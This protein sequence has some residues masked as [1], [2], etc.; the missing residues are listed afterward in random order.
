MQA[1]VRAATAL[2]RPPLPGDIRDAFAAPYASADR[3]HG[4]GDFVA[5]IPLETD[6]PSRK[7][8]DDIADGIETLDDVPVLLLWGTR[9]PVFG[10]AYLRDLIARLPH[11][12]VHRY[13]Q[14]SHLLME[15][16]PAATGHVWQWVA[17]LDRA[18]PVDRSP[19][20][21]PERQIWSALSDPFR[22][23]RAGRGRA[24]RRAFHRVLRSPRRADS[25]T[26]RRVWPRPVCARATA[27]RC[28]SRPAPT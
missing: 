23:P 1:F 6:H 21:V 28:S 16:A 26:S 25:A 13:Q 7:T 15:D 22:R 3:R 8:L 24:R 11:A 2:S 10:E 20:S 19:V 9:D 17:D 4:V 5:D 12:A 14:A 27:W 18:T